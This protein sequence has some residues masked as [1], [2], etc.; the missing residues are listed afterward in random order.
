ME[1]VDERS[2]LTGPNTDSDICIDL[3]IDGTYTLGVLPFWIPLAAHVTDCQGNDLFD[4][5]VRFECVSCIISWTHSYSDSNGVARTLIYPACIST[6]SVVV[7]ASYG[8][9]TVSITIN[10]P[11]FEPEI[12]IECSHPSTGAAGYHNHS[13]IK[14]SYLCSGEALLDVSLLFWADR[15]C[16]H[17]GCN[18]SIYSNNQGEA[19]QVWY[20]P[21]WG[22]TATSDAEDHNEPQNVIIIV[23]DKSTGYEGSTAIT[24]YPLHARLFID[25]SQ[26]FKKETLILPTNSVVPITVYLFW[27]ADDVDYPVPF[28]VRLSVK[29]FGESNASVEP[30]IIYNGKVAHL[31][32]GMNKGYVTLFASIEEHGPGDCCYNKED[33]WL[34]SDQVNLKIE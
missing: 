19:S 32:S 15:G 9:T 7:S 11:E 6:G 4:L 20:P 27:R 1:N 34:W 23:A 26:S 33:G 31:Y 14:A 8:G 17:H 16:F 10:I 30:V 13:L 12:I 22:T 2:A 28:P 21:M 18:S 29:N 3:Y 25:D 5:P 24:L